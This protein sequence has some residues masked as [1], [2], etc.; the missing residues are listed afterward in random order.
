MSDFNDTIARMKQ[1]YTYG[2]VKENSNKQNNHTLEFTKKGADGKYYGIVKEY[3]QYYIKQTVDGKQNLAESYD[4]IGG[5]MNKKNYQYDSYANALKNL[6]L[7]LSSINEACDAKIDI[8]TLDPFKKEIVLAE[9]SDKMRDSIARQRQI[10]YNAGMI[11]G[12]SKDYAVKGG[13]A[14]TTSQPEAENGPK[15]DKPE[16]AKEAKAEPEFDG[17]HVELD[18]K[19]VPFEKNPGKTQDLKENSETN[20]NPMLP[21]TCNWG[22]EGLGKGEEPATIGWDIEGQEKV[23]EDTDVCPDCGKS[24]DDCTCK[25]EVNEEGEREWASEGL[26]SDAQAGVGSPD[27]HLMEDDETEVDVLDDEEDEPI[28]DD[29]DMLDDETVGETEPVVDDEDTVVDDEDTFDEEEPTEEDDIFDD[30]EPEVDETDAA[31]VEAEIARLQGVLADLKGE[32]ESVDEPVVDSEDTFDEEEP[33]EEPEVD[34]EDTFDEDVP[35]ED[36]YQFES[37][38][39]VMNTIIESVVASYK[40]ALNEDELHVFGDHP[41][42]RK[43]P[44]NL[45]PTGEDKNEHG[46]DIND[47]SVHNEE[48]FGKQIGDSSPFNELVK[49]VAKDVVYQLKHG[50]PLDNKK[51][52]N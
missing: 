17:N 44:M 39:R 26:P 35:E 47:E 33:V 19:A 42:Y 5:Y 32:E 25:K 46:E 12:E 22:S 14:C 49:A 3:N 40:N 6:E 15:G 51:K 13:P 34:N 7:K 52:E 18:K 29:E 10:M 27:G 31:S 41:G 16:G 9:A 45:P 37:K 24:C 28:V 38:K 4:Y 21:N 2:V 20:D 30:E 36:D 8:T 43:K 50:A 23:N 1:L 11:M 48:P